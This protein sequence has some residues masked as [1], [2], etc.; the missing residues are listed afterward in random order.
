MWSN[1]HTHTPYC[2]GKSEAVEYIQTAIQKN[3]ISLGFS[4]HAPL[5]FECK[6][7]MKPADL[8]AYFTEINLLKKSIIN[9][10]VYTGL[11]VDF[12][13]HVISPSKFRGKLDY[14]IGSIHFVGQLTN[15]QHWE[16]D[17]QHT[18]FLSGLKELFNND[19]RDA[20]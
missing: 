6:W 20:I 2:D 15:G 14:T 18:L 9:V 17:G 8:D 11:E 19:I 10:E 5:P 4:S 1:L 7:C 13:P 16:I 12:I 3:I